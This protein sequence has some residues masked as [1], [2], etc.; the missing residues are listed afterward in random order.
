MNCSNLDLIV[1]SWC[2]IKILTPVYQTKLKTNLPRWNAATQMFVLLS[3]LQTEGII[4]QEQTHG[5]GLE[6]IKSKNFEL[7]P[8]V[9]SG[10]AVIQDQTNNRGTSITETRFS[11]KSADTASVPAWC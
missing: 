7:N 5:K 4:M 6:N 8:S 11:V 10:E 9:K 1:L 2:N 3:I